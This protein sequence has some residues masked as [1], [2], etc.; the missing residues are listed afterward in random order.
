MTARTAMVVTET[1]M[2]ASTMFGSAIAMIGVC[3]VLSMLRI[4]RAKPVAVSTSASEGDDLATEASSPRS[5]GSVYADGPAK[6]ESY[7][8]LGGKVGVVGRKMVRFEFEVERV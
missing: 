3:F 1:P 4:S 8:S 7:G 6:M 2:V 5:Q